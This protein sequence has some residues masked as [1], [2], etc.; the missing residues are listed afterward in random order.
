MRFTQA[1]SRGFVIVFAC[2]VKLNPFAAGIFFYVTG[3]K[4]NAE[5]V[6]LVH[7]R[8]HCLKRNGIHKAAI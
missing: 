8:K 6:A 7:N 5:R 2:L 1:L 4:S 3:A